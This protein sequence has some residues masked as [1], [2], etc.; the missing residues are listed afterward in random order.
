MA[1]LSP[2][3]DDRCPPRSRH[4]ALRWAI[5]ALLGL[6]VHGV[7]HAGALYKCVNGEGQIAYTNKPAGLIDCVKLS[8]FVDPPP[9]KT[10]TK[11]AGID[12]T[13]V[14]NPN[15]RSGPGA[16]LPETLPAPIN[17]A[18]SATAAV[19]PASATPLASE[20]SVNPW[21]KPPAAA[22]TAATDFKVQRGSVYKV[23]RA[24]GIV[25]YTNVKPRDH[26]PIEVLFTY[27]AT[28]S[29][30]DVHSPIDWNHTAL[31]LLAYHDEVVT[32]ALQFGVPEALL[33]AVIH[34]ESAFNPNALSSKGAQGLMQLMP[35][36]ATD[37]GVV[38]PWNAAENIRGGAQYLAQLL[39]HFNGDER[40]AAAAYNS[41][42]ANVR[43]YA[44]VP[45][46]DE[47]QVYVERVGTLRQR[48]AGMPVAAN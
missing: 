43:K 46:F 41:G 44:G 4:D 21:L 37:L 38:N 18:V 10:Q 31:N 29:A 1:F 32:A 30:C 12:T 22:A 7:A 40:L 24:N 35:D 9:L 45:P 19:S 23:S 11:S 42:E 13:K 17:A 5:G 33:R 16:S 26:S 20:V 8:S 15:Y 2:R 25:E 39:K 27:I 28:C 36:T 47:T 34:A 48:Y 14:S 6:T 3:I